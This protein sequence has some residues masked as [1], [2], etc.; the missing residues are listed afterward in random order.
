MLD[1]TSV[2]YAEVEFQPIYR[3]QPLFSAVDEFMQEKGFELIDLFHQVRMTPSTEQHPISEHGVQLMWADALY[4]KK[5]GLCSETMMLDQI[6]IS[7][8]VFGIN[9]YATYLAE[10]YDRL[11]SKQI[12][13]EILSA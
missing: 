11:F 5:S 10:E 3:D 1:R 9:P 7:A 4:L 6:A 8:L 13:K 2:V 12:T